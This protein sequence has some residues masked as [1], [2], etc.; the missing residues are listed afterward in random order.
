MLTDLVIDGNTVMF[1][2]GGILNAGTLMI[3]NSTIGGTIGNTAVFGGGIYNDIGGRLTITNSTIAK[4][5]ASFAGGGILNSGTLTITNST[6]AKNTAVFG[7]G[8]GII[9]FAGLTLNSTI[10]AL[11]TADDGAGPG[12][13]P[14]PGP[15]I[16]N[17]TSGTIEADFSLIGDTTFNDITATGENIVNTAAGFATGVLADNG[18]PTETLALASTSPAIDAGAA[19]GLNFDQRGFGPRDV[20]GT[21]D[22]GAYEFGAKPTPT[23]TQEVHA[24]LD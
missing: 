19:N 22:I 7:G 20:D 4:N 9:N 2:G 15:D 13:G 10:V 17:I 1:F 3:T 12:P 5:T 11:N 8:G 18:G 16:F 21:A 14:G 6:I 23:L 24:R